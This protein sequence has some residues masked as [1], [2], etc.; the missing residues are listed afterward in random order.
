MNRTVSIRACL[1]G[2][3]P[4]LRI[5]DPMRYAINDS[6]IVANANA[7]ISSMP[8]KLLRLKTFIF[9]IT[10]YRFYWRGNIHIIFLCPYL[11]VHVYVIT[12]RYTNKH[13]HAH[14]KKTRYMVNI[15]KRN[16]SNFG[17]LKKKISSQAFAINISAFK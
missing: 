16:T 17:Y 11:F 7:I 6:D 3:Y 1:L 4:G 8:T 14:K 10:C 15:S 12:C 2:S 5:V 9:L 13:T